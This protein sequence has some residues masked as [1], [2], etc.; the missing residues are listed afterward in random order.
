MARNWCLI[1]HAGRMDQLYVNDDYSKLF[2]IVKFSISCPT[3]ALAKM[4]ITDHAELL[5]CRCWYVLSKICGFRQTCH[6]CKT[7]NKFRVRRTVVI[8]HKFLVEWS[9]KLLIVDCWIY[10]RRFT[11]WMLFIVYVLC[12]GIETMQYIANSQCKE[13]TLDFLK[14]KIYITRCFKV[15]N[16]VL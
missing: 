10:N 8:W 2:S 12:N 13:H 9:H 14:M 4:V 15:L 1:M 16:G 5:I 3:V 6:I 11:Q 7:S